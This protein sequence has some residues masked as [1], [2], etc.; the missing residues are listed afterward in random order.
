[1]PAF[2]MQKIKNAY[3]FFKIKNAKHILS[4]IDAH[5]LQLPS[6]SSFL[7]FHAHGSDQSSHQNDFPRM[8]LETVDTGHILLMS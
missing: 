3:I 5:C 1:M 2:A 7:T 4:S 6:I 8:E